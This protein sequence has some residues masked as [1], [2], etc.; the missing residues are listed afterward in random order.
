M[1]PRTACFVRVRGGIKADF[2]GKGCSFLYQHWLGLVCLFSTVHRGKS[3]VSIVFKLGV[4]TR[5]LRESES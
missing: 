1:S 2:A 4:R 5:D 3:S